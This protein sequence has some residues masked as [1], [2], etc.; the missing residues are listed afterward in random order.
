MSENR[1]R[2]GA[3][4]KF[5]LHNWLAITLVALAAVFIGQNRGRQEVRFL[6]I[7]VGSPMWLLL[8]GMLVVGIVA[9]LLLG[10]RRN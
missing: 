3:V 4:A 10:R 1:S 7:T 5:A 6:W 8:A 2:G 9:G